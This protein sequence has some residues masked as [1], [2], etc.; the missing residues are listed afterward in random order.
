MVALARAEIL[1]AID[2]AVR[3]VDALR[4]R[5]HRVIKDALD[6]R[7]ADARDTEAGDCPFFARGSRAAT[8]ARRPRVA[9][10]V[11]VTAQWRLMTGRREWG[12]QLG[13]ENLY[14]L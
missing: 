4:D 13:Q 1:P 2:S 10:R 6:R 12:P 5:T 7:A 9:R 14:K 3:T 8:A 11:V